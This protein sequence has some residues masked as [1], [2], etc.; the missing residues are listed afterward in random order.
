MP[1][2][3]D[4]V[5]TNHTVDQSADERSHREGAWHP[6]V[7][8]LDEHSR[9]GWELVDVKVSVTTGQNKYG[10]LQRTRTVISVWRRPVTAPRSVTTETHAAANGDE[11]HT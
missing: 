6:L 7:A 1:F 11:S 4:I 10:R 9:E 2:E 8:P 3:F 5:E